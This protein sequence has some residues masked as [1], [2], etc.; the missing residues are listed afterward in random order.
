MT[1]TR[2]R[3]SSQEYI[4][5]PHGFCPGCGVTLA[6]RYF[7][8]AMGSRIV[9]VMPPGCASP[10]V[11]FPKRSLIDQGRLIDIVACPFG[12]TAIFAGG[13]KTA[14]VARGD[15]ET[16]VVGWAGDGATF[17]IGLGGVSAAAERNEDILYVC[18]DNEAYMNTGNQR[19]SATP[20]GAKTSTNRPPTVKDETKKDLMWMM[21]GHGIPYGATA[22]IAYPDDLMA[23]VRKAKEIKGFRFFHILTPCVPGWGYPSERTVEISRLA[24]QTRVFPLFEIEGDRLVINKHPK[25]RDLKEFVG[26]QGRFKDL[27]DADVQRL[28]EEVERRWKRLNHMAGFMEQPAAMHVGH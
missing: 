25:A 19:S 17:D 8:K 2:S 24:V 13:I 28:Q 14:F 18:Y 10:S 21:M 5:P 6:L 11:L 26:V 3:Y 12:S 1:G 4:Q 15:S 27:S 23:K 20:R 9:L 16:Q 22:T 7:L